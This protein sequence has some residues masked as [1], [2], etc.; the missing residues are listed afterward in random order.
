L[1]FATGDF[2]EG[3]ANPDLFGKET[4]PYAYVGEGYIDYSTDDLTLCIGRQ[5]I[6]TPFAEEED[7]RMHPNTFEAAIATYK[8]I[9]DMTFVGGYISRWA[10]YDSGDD[11]SKFKKLA[12]GSNG[13]IMIGMS[14]E[15]LD[16]LE[17]SGWYYG[18]DKL[19]D[20]FYGDA[21]YTL[22]FGEAG[23]LELIGQLGRFNAQNNSNVEG[24]I[25]GIGANLN[26]GILTLGAEYNK[27]SNPSGKHIISG[28]GNGPYVVDTEE[29]NLDDF[30]DVNVYQFNAELEMEGFGTLTA[31]YSNFKSAPQHLEVD[32]INLIALYKITDAVGAEINYVIVN[33]KN[34]NTANNGIENYDGGYDRLMMR[35]KY[36]F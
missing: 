11:I 20:I 35:L 32:E 17:L 24:N 34:K 18:I 5:R 23:S 10:G 33:D 19:S 12:P 31:S 6:N 15:S 36:T 14:N 2:N 16:D 30:E 9:G 21:T 27:A 28:F 13:A 25:Y 26:L 29:V 1:P 8:G 7:I 22:E 3:K 4:R